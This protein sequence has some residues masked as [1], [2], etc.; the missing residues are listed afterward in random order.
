MVYCAKKETWAELCGQ[1]HCN[2]SNHGLCWILLSVIIMS[3]VGLDKEPAKMF[4][5]AVVLLAQKGESQV[6]PT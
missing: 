4:V 6:T 1:S 3:I 2:H 5:G